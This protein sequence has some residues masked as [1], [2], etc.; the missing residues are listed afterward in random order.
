MGRRFVIVRGGGVG[1]GGIAPA[2]VYDRFA[3]TAPQ[4]AQPTPSR[5]YQ[6]ASPAPT[7]QP[8]GAVYMPQYPWVYPP[9]DAEPFDPQTWITMPAVV[10]GTEVQVLALTVPLGKNG[11][12]Q[13]FGNVVI[14]AGWVEG[15]GD[16]IWRI[17][18]DG[19][20]VR[21]YQNILA[22]LG[23]VSNPVDCGIRIFENE[24]IQ[25]VIEN[26]ALVPGGQQVGAR[27]RGW[28]YPKAHDEINAWG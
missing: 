21:N 9:A 17:L 5:I 8:S 12:I 7:T 25:V 11:V 1:L 10:P 19:A 26:V 22:S 13:K 23:N 27:L 16:L 28:F 15:T 18:R 14:G 4:P 24:V 3:A 6:P 2:A 20:A